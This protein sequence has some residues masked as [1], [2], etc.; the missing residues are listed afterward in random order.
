MLQRFDHAENEVDISKALLEE[1][2]SVAGP[3][4][5]DIEVRRCSNILVN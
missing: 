4:E 1:K 3:S 2:E 5:V